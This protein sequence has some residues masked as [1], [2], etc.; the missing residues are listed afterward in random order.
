MKAGLVVV[1]F[2]ELLVE[3]PTVRFAFATCVSL[4]ALML[5]L[6]VADVVTRPVAPLRSP[7]GT[8]ARDRG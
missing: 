3:R 5:A 7:A 1:F 4:F 6:V 2:M 8:Q